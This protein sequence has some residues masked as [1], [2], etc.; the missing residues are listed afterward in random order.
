MMIIDKKRCYF[1]VFIFFQIFISLKINTKCMTVWVHGT[2]P[3]QNLLANRYSP[4]RS[5]IYTKEGLSLA[6]QL[7]SHYNFFKIA[8]ECCRQNSKEYDLN[9]FYTYGWNSAKLSSKHRKEVG[10]NLYKEVQKILENK[11]IDSL[12]LIGFSHGGNVVLNCL[13]FLPFNCRKVNIEVILIATPVQ[14]SNKNNINNPFI[15]KAYSLYSDGD[16]IQRIDMQK[17]HSL[18]PKRSPWWSK[19]IFD[20]NSNVIQV[21]MTQK[22]KS[23]GHLKYRGLLKYL[24][25]VIKQVDEKLRDHQSSKLVFLNVDF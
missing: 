5:K 24:P 17:M 23:F 1:F 12:R 19:R 14:E 20:K 4:F 2:H 15:D 11:E 18:A 16:W 9:F 25:A 8:Q 3:A 7:P 10:K 22:G 13:E 6:K 21:C